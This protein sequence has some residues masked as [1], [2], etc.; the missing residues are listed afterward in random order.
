VVITVLRTSLAVAVAAMTAWPAGAAAFGGPN[1]TP[2]AVAAC[3]STVMTQFGNNI[4]NRRGA[5]RGIPAPTSC[6]HYFQVHGYI[7]NG[8]PGQLTSSG[9]R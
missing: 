9:S 7:G 3:E 8:P 2:Q 5:K 6:D 4:F 1:P